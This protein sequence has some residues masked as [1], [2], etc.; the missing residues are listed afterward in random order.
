MVV[1][2][3]KSLIVSIQEK[4]SL[5][6][7]NSFFFAFLSFFHLMLFIFIV[8]L[9]FVHSDFNSWFQRSNRTLTWILWTKHPQSVHRL[10]H[11]CTKQWRSEHTLS[12]ANNNSIEW[13]LKCFVT[14]TETPTEI[15]IHTKFERNSWRDF[16][17]Q[18]LEGNV[19]LVVV[20]IHFTA[21]SPH[22]LHIFWFPFMNSFEWV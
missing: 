2:S 19:Y 8:S 17:H 13:N 20:L 5:F 6:L 9:F 21:K 15:N 1:Q 22:S 7:P 10:L 12:I 11:N 14:I 16:R 3:K 18:H 4:W